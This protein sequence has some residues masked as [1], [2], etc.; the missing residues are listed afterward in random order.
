VTDVDVLVL[1]GSP[2]SGKTTLSRAL[3]EHL[4]VADVPHAVI[5]LDDISIVH[6][7]PGRDFPRANL[8][9]LWPNYAAVA[10]GLRL[11]LPTVLADEGEAGLL[12]AAAPG[13]TF[14]VCELTAPKPVLYERVTAREPND[15]WQ[16]RLRRWVDVFTART[17]L[18]RIRDFQ[19]TTHDKTIEQAAAEILRKAGWA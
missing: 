2:G 3:S 16:E 17:D 10:P 12:R 11:I 1:H 15:F 4:R 7:Y 6:P 18:A 8:S 13:R 9:A 5:D 14:T 19:V